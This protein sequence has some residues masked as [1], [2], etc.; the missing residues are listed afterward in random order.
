MCIYFIVQ[1]YAHFE[2]CANNCLKKYMHIAKLTYRKKDFSEGAREHCP[3][4]LVNKVNIYFMTLP[5]LTKI[6]TINLKKVFMFKLSLLLVLSCCLFSALAQEK[7]R[8]EEIIPATI[9]NIKGHQHLYNEGWY[10]VTSTQK[11]LDFAYRKMISESGESLSQMGG[12]SQA[13]LKG[14]AHG[15]TDNAKEAAKDSK[16][17]FK[18]GTAASL[19]LRKSGNEL[20][21]SQFKRSKEGFQKSWESFTL[22]YIGLASQSKEDWKELKQSYTGFGD[23]V[24]EDFRDLK[25]WFESQGVNLSTKAESSWKESFSKARQEFQNEYEESGRSGN[26]LKGLGHI[27]WGY[28]KALYYGVMKPSTESA[29][30]GGKA[31]VKGITYPLAGAVIVANRTVLSLGQNFLFVGKSVVRVLSPTVEAGFMTSLALFNG[32]SAPLLRA[33]SEGLYAVNQVAVTAATPVVG[34]GKYLLSE[35]G[36]VATNTAILSYS[37]V[38]GAADVLINQAEAAVVLGYNAITAIPTQ[39]VLGVGNTVILLAW[40]GPRLALY[41]LKGEVDFSPPSGL[42]LDK[43]KLE[44]HKK[45]KLEKISDDPQVIQKVLE[46]LPQDLRE[47]K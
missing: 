14:M 10:V 35:A 45:F 17:F 19:D 28:C 20:S 29:E 33:G 41:T 46:E 2:L 25:L 21:S 40:D 27:F 22:G 8:V 13:A 38:T 47:K 30:S 36:D 24:K 7:K 23:N 1:L 3:K 39:V 42:V 12:T 34:T 18:K 16:V 11:S 43:K 32:A 31:L 37:V 26:T 44:G 6:N 9:S 15:V 4:S 5:L